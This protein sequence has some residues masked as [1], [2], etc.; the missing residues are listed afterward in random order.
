MDFMPGL[1]MIFS[2]KGW[3]ALMGTVSYDRLASQLTT[4]ICAPKPAILSR[5]C[6][7]KPVRIATARIIT[8]SPSAMPMMA[9][10]LIGREKEV[11]WLRSLISR[12]AMNVPVDIG[13]KLRKFLEGNSCL[14][15]PPRVHLQCLCKRLHRKAQVV[16]LKYI[17]NS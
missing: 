4:C 14:I 13:T 7:L 9:I 8:A 1:L 15:N 17:G 12:R 6:C 11:S 3:L 5:I 2:T 10:T 16:D